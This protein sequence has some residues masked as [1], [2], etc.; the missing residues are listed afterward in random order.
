M[1]LPHH[2][3]R[4]TVRRMTVALTI[5]ILSMGIGLQFRREYYRNLAVRHRKLSRANLRKDRMSFP[6]RNARDRGDA[7]MNWFVYQLS[8]AREYDRIADFPWLPFVPPP[9][10]PR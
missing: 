10:P 2:R 3:P 9:D 1:R 5:L 8:I 6:G 7:A 4:F